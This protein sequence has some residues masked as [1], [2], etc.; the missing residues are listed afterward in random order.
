MRRFLGGVLTGIVVT[1]AFFVGIG[2]VLDVEDPL[3]PADVLVA[4]SVEVAGSAFH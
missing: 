3:V 2:H 1:C 4:L